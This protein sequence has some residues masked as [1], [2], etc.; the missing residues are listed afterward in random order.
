MTT[1]LIRDGSFDN[2]LNL[3]FAGEIKKAFR[4]AQLEDLRTALPNWL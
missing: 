2:F 4:S 3:T 1:P